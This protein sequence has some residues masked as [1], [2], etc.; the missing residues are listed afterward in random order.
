[1]SKPSLMTPVEAALINDQRPLPFAVFN[2]DGVLLAPRGVR[3][4]RADQ[5]HVLR[6]EGWRHVESTEDPPAESTTEPYR[7]AAPDGQPTRLKV[8]RQPLRA[9]SALV[10]DDMHLAR[11]LLSRMLQE[12][13][14]RHVVAAE[15]GREAIS[16]FF[17]QT[18]TLVFL[19]IDMPNVDGLQALEQIKGW[20]PNA[21]ACLVSGNN[22]RDNVTRAL[23][24]GVDG[25]LV[26][27]MAPLN[28]KRLLQ[29]YQ[30]ESS[31]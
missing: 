23:E 26:K 25:F 19:D 14:I 22:T 17:L 3:L 12:L 13:G 16:E 24:L 30:P 28:L 8:S 9:C 21:F 4:S 5:L 27:P 31:A 6:T 15:S 2:A 29:K 7:R 18:P 20:S 11:S 1:M 10:A